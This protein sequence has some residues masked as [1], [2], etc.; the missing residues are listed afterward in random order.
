MMRQLFQ[1]ILSNSLKYSKLSRPPVIDIGFQQ[2]DKYYEFSFRDNGI[3]FD[4]Q[5][6]PQMFTL[7]QRLHDKKE[8]EGTGLGLAICRK[9]VDLH[10]GKIWA[11]GKEGEGA[12]F[13]VSLPVS[14][15]GK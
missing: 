13:Y 3:G 8:Y 14:Q 4:E 12:V 1:N 9:I 6:L 15:S 2:K 10:G 5:Y 7:F 11:E